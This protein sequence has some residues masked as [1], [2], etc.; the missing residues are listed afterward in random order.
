MRE[1]ERTR[2]ILLVMTARE[3]GG[4]EVYAE[5]L[6]HALAS[7]C[8]FTIALADHPNMRELSARLR[9]VAC[10]QTFPFDQVRH[11]ATVTS[12][13]Q[14]LA[15][16]H[17]VTHLNSNHPASRLGVFMGFALGRSR[18]PL[19]C[20]EHRATPVADVHVPRQI[21]WAMPMLFR[22]SRRRAACVIAV[23]RENARTLVESSRLPAARVKVVYNGIALEPFHTA[24]KSR[25]LREEL[26]LRD[27]QPIILVLARLRPSK[28]H[29]YLIQAA[30]AILA[31]FPQAHFVFAGSPEER[32]PLDRQIAALAL[33]DRFS[34]LGFRPDPVNL[35]CG[36][37]LFVLP[38]LAEGFALSL[39][40]AL[41]A[42]LP[43]I[44]TNVGGADEIISDGI[45]GFL[46]PPADAH[47]LARAVVR[48]LSLDAAAR[49]QLKRAALETARRFSVQ[50]TARKMFEVYADPYAHRD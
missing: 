25:A 30:P 44:A 34:I 46:V 43:V 17:D 36:S 8:Q 4:A 22:W 32:A 40:E 47:A 2:H 18:T 35:L 45:N 6:V 41:A 28:G 26:G 3:I 14:R 16:A 33:S 49:A 9:Q 50:E 24:T 23:S 10:V 19:V 1:N 39:I 31:R 27:D 42:G 11:L 5:R 20:V 12:E 21:A 48:A 29:R 38:S 7:R 15:D 13:L 37:D